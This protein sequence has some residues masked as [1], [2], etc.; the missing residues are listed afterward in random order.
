MKL[1]FCFRLSILLVSLLLSSC[2]VKSGQVHFSKQNDIQKSLEKVPSI[3]TL[4]SKVRVGISYYGKNIKGKG[5]LYFKEDKM[6]ILLLDP[7]KSPLFDLIVAPTFS[8]LVDYK[9]MGYI[10]LLIKTC[11]DKDIIPPNFHRVIPVFFQNLDGSLR[12]NI[13]QVVFNEDATINQLDYRTFGAGTSESVSIEYDKYIETKTGK[14]PTHFILQK[15][16]I[17][18]LI[19]NNEIEMELYGDI[20]VNQEVKETLF[21]TARILKLRNLCWKKGNVRK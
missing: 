4:E 5:Y 21:A 12:E 9:N 20:L 2:G 7:L 17:D 8:Y 11:V 18:S 6:R 15:K 13:E 16:S 3:K 14:V 1:K 10:D 19:L